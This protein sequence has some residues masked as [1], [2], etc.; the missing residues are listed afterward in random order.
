MIKIQVKLCLLQNRRRWKT[1]TQCNL[2]KIVLCNFFLV[3]NTFLCLL[4]TKKPQQSEYF[5]HW[6]DFSP[7][8]LIRSRFLCYR[9]FRSLFCYDFF[10]LTIHDKTGCVYF[11]QIWKNK[12]NFFERN[13][14]VKLH[15]KCHHAKGVIMKSFVIFF[16]P[17]FLFL[18]MIQKSLPFSFLWIKNLNNAF[19]LLYKFIFSFRPK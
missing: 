4:R 7:L 3:S 9:A 15:W 16:S 1:K 13:A 18:I 10:C 5:F 14:W 17:R 6:Q 19:G 2:K 8:L 12:V 11:S